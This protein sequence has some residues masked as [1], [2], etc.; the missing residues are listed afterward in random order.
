MANPTLYY[1]GNGECTI[2]GTDILGVEIRYTGAVA[3]TSTCG[4]GCFLNANDNGIIIVSLN[5]NPLN[6]LFSYIGTIKI[7]SIIVADKNG[8]RVYCSLKKVMDYSELLDSNSE[9][10]TVKSEDLNAGYSHKRSF[11][12][13]SVSGNVIR[14]QHSNGELYLKNGK[15]YSGAYHIHGNGSAYTG[16]EYT[17]TSVILYTKN[18]KGRSRKT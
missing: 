16:G 2:E 9:D 17:E 13:T 14:N 4:G 10:L 3:I 15:S 11:K 7:T 18:K 1:G 6:N 5:G 8:E 12:K